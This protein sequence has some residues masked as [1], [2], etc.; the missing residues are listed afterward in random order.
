M[1][2]HAEHRWVCP[3]CTQTA[4]THEATAQHTR[5]HTCAGLKGLTAPLVRAGVSCKV[6]AVQREDYVG[7]DLPHVDGDGRVVMAVRVTRD[8]GEDCVVLAPTASM[9]GGA[10]D[11]A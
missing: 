6:T 4:V 9:H 7:K 2:L 3:N 1:L 10:W 5:L 11:R 8:E